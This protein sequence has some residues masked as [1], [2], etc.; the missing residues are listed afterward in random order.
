MKFH[1]PNKK[2][3]HLYRRFL[4]RPVGG[5]ILLLTTRG[6]KSGRPHTVGLQ[7]ELIEGQYY[8][9]AADG[10]SADWYRN[11]LI[12]PEVEVQVGDRTFSAT[13]EV[14]AQAERIVEFLEYR[15]KKH[16]LMIRLILRLDGIKGNL[17]RGSLQA[18]AE[19][20]RLVILTP[21]KS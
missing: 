8:V 15:I 3:V 17:D 14:C 13:A 4:H 18:Y 12:K 2:F 1:P 5:Q 21:K 19:K 7:Y 16:P 10:E 11:L 9:G 6:R 20:I